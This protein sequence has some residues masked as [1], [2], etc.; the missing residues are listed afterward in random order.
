MAADEGCD[1]D[2]PEFRPPLPPEDRIW[3]HP[4]ELRGLQ[5]VPPAD[6]SGGGRSPW[7][8][9]FVSAIGGVLLAGSLMFGMG[10]LG[11]E[12][13]RIALEPIATLEPRDDDPE[14]LSGGAGTDDTPGSES[15]FALDISTGT[16]VRSGCAVV[17]RADGYLVTTATLVAGATDI[18][19]TADDGTQHVGRVVGIDAL[20]D[21]AVV[22]VANVGLAAA[23]LDP[24]A[25]AGI[26]APVRVLGASRGVAHPAWE[27]SVRDSSTRLVTD[28]VDLHGALQLDEK[29]DTTAAGAPVIALDEGTIVGIATTSA[30]DGSAHVIPTKTVLSVSEQLIAWG[31]ARHGWMG[32]EGVNDDDRG[33]L[34]RT[35]IDASPAHAAGLL[36]GDRI[37]AVDSDEI[38]T[39][40]D[41]V[42]AVRE[43]EP[44]SVVTLGVLRDGT[45]ITLPVTLTTMPTR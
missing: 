17:L 32:I 31:E 39:M 12:P 28:I 20:N 2:G 25:T 1:D 9:G 37:V 42:V 14:P 44:G 3:R 30:A 38:A 5:A 45:A 21:L 41:L 8:V 11:N 13:A 34:V 24:E 43:R 6:R 22:H 15:V 23:P 4:A 36:A 10:G 27:A 16:D 40:S 35:V 18:R 7:T 26:G 29:L 19:L 33:A